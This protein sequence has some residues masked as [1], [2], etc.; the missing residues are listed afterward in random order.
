MICKLIVALSLLGVQLAAQDSLSNCKSDCDSLEQLGL[1]QAGWSINGGKLLHKPPTSLPAGVSIHDTAHIWIKVL[2]DSL[3]VPN[4]FQILKSENESLNEH[5]LS[6]ARQYR[7][8]P[9][10]Y[11]GRRLKCFVVI[12]L[13][14]AN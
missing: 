14:F 5:A 12:P 8:T 3:G 13:K 6:L 1:D 7:F 4:C 10:T 2:V 11:E 9:F